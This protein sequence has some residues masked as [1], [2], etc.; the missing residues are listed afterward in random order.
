MSALPKWTTDIF[1]KEKT[2][3]YV[4]RCQHEAKIYFQKNKNPT[5]CPRCQGCPRWQ[6]WWRGS[7]E[8][9]QT[10]SSPSQRYTEYKLSLQT[11]YKGSISGEYVLPLSTSTRSKVLCWAFSCHG[12]SSRTWEAVHKVLFFFYGFRFFIWLDLFL[13]IGLSDDM[14]TMNTATAASCLGLYLYNRYIMLEFRWQV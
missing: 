11:M 8:H 2:N 1:S 3:N 5:R 14:N 6:R 12:S 9:S 4:Q 7:R 13:S 10:F